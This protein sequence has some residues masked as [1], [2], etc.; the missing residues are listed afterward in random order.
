MKNERR[1][2]IGMTLINTGDEVEMTCVIRKGSHFIDLQPLGV[3][4][5]VQVCR[6]DADADEFVHHGLVQQTVQRPASISAMCY[7]YSNIIAQRIAAISHSRPV[8][9]PTYVRAMQVYV[10]TYM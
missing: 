7:A 8:L 9:V 4:V 10:G 5:H 6:S 1:A 3:I 2:T